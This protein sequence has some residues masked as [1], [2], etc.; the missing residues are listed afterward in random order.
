LALNKYV[1]NDTLDDWK[2]YTLQFD[3]ECDE[4]PTGFEFA[5]FYY[6]KTIFI[7]GQAIYAGRGFE[8]NP[9]YGYVEW[10][11]G[12]NYP[13]PI[14]GWKSVKRN[15]IEITAEQ[16]LKLAEESGGRLARLSVQ[17]KCSIGVNIF[18]DTGWQIYINDDG[19]GWLYHAE[20][21]P[22]TGAI[23]LHP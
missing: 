6:Y 2:V 11:S 16:A 15:K 3:T 10:G 22:F 9:K 8:V 12:P 19:V 23:N 4:N 13:H 17:N 18:G 5:H 20:I 21:N 7:H 14:L 1:W